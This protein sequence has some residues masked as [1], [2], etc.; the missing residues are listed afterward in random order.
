MFKHIRFD[1][2][3]AWRLFLKSPG[4]SLLC[5]LV[6]A[7]SVGLSL[8]VYVIDYN[9]GLKPLPFDGAG[10]WLSIQV[11]ENGSSSFRPRVDPYTYQELRKRTQT[12]DYLG[13][14]SP[15]AP[16]MSEGEASTRLRGAAIS[17]L[18]LGA[19]GTAPL[20]GRLFD[21]RDSSSGAAPTVILSY[22]TWETYFASDAQ[23]V[24][25]QIHMDGGTAQVVGVMPRDFFAF[26]DFEVWMPLQLSLMATPD[27]SQ[28]EVTPIVTPKAGSDEDAVVAD[29]SQ[30]LMEINSNFPQ[31][32]SSKRDIAVFPAHRMYTH[33]NI[34][35]IAMATF[36]AL[37]VL[38]LGGL[39][40]S[41]IF[42]AMLLERSRELA[43]RTAL[44]S[45]RLRILRQCL[46]QSMFVIAFGLVLGGILAWLAVDWAHGLL[47]FTARLQATGRDPNELV[48]RPLDLSV[49]LLAAVILWLL[50]TLIPAWRISHL[51]PATTLAGT[52][53]GMAG[54]GSSRTT[55][56]LVGVQ[57]VV[58]C[59]LLVI[60]AN[61]AMAVNSELTK[62]VGVATEQRMLSTYPSVLGTRYAEP[63]DRLRYWDQL[64]A[65]IR[66]RI[67]SAGVAYM[68]ASPT[69]PTM[70]AAE[71]E[72]YPR[73]AD[74]NKLELP[75]S[76]VSAGYFDILDIRILAGRGFESN[77]DTSAQLVAVIDKR[78][79][80]RYWPGRSPLGQ[81][82]RFDPQ[83]GGPWITVVG[84]ASAVRGPYSDADGVVYRPLRQ[85]LPNSFQLLVK[86]PAASTDSRG[87]LR[88]AAFDV[89]PDVPLHNLQRLDEY[90]VAINSYKSMVPG[91]TGI[92][93]VTV[94]LA[95]SGLF[96]LIS[97]SV[98]QRTQ[99]IGVMRALGST[100]YRVIC[101][102]MLQAFWYL[103]I[104]LI[105]CVVGVV[106]T[107]SMTGVVPNALDSVIPVTIGVVLVM[108]AVIFGS[109]YVPARRAVAMEPGDALRYE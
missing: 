108:A 41:M 27:P 39:N 77:D 18:L 28:S 44:G 79:A 3:Y 95:A 73:V 64:R 85:A 74:D 109:S 70:V 45:T 35:V 76:T 65:S 43:L 58:S 32:Y 87:L 20:H 80:E 17:P 78:T 81:R 61:V 30:A 9:I 6:V 56:I 59:L 102:F 67:P 88:A 1:F 90:L 107:T 15:R 91:F 38:L 22:N 2:T 83:E 42:F 60:C 71:I 5:I 48:M 94:I 72:D 33:G 57:V 47:D 97:R 55:N 19:M 4:N 29:L 101:R 92:A 93:L 51:D 62:P 46:L 84:V 63:E 69:A 89:D 31:F 105:G 7:L 21:D 68:T 75:V 24:G 36:I 16:I 13:A 49:A 54:K 99:E 103:C 25:E 53:K 8:F 23:I 52:G 37:A 106:L 104:G 82:L 10:R 98:A 14:F 26:Q 96:G 50:S 34:P 11:A 40:I 12:I 66:Q 86:L 100:R